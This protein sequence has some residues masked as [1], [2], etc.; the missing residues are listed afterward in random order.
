MECESFCSDSALKGCLSDPFVMSLW[1]SEVQWVARRQHW[2]A[3]G[4]VQQFPRPVP[5]ERCWNTDPLTPI[6]PNDS[7]ASCADTHT[8]YSRHPFYRHHGRAWRTCTI[9]DIYTAVVPI[10]L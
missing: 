9:T 6:T 1:W 2:R 3:G 7:R 8:L 4:R 5:A 10:F